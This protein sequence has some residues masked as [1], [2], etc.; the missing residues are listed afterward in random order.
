[1]KMKMKM[2][3]ADQKDVAKHSDIIVS[4]REVKAIYRM[5]P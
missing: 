5:S 2:S 4:E 3:Q 1:M